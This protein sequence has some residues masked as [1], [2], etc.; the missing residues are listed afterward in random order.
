MTARHGG[1]G[2]DELG[3][4]ST[5]VHPAQD[6]AVF[7]VRF[8]IVYAILEAN[9]KT[10]TLLLPRGLIEGVALGPL[11]VEREPAP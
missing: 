3:S 2:P 7:S 8:V 11:Q 5:G 9:S 10:T 1:K 6:W 4:S